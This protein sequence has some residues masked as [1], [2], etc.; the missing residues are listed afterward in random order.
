VAI[1]TS[2]KLDDAQLIDEVEEASGKTSVMAMSDARTAVADFL[3]E[4]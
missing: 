2:A 3:M 1:D 4:Y